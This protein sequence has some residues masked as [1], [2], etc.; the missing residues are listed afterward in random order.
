M[1]D[2]EPEEFDFGFQMI[3]ISISSED[4]PLSIDLGGVSPLLAL[5]ILGNAIET[6]N[7]LVPHC[8]VSANGQEVVSVVDFIDDDE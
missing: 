5:A 4:E 8:N 2:V 7:M 1:S 6:L 3:T